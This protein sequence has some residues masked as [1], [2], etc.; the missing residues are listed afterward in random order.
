MTIFCCAEHCIQYSS[1]EHSQA[2]MLY[3]VS[4]CVIWLELEL[5]FCYCLLFHAHIMYHASKVLKSTVTD[6]FERYRYYFLV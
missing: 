4:A 2:G 1:I 5:K 6:D 3:T